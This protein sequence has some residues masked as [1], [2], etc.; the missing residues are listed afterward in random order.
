VSGFSGY[1]GISGFSGYSG[2]SGFSGYS[3]RSGYS[4]I[5]GFSGYSAVSGFS[6]YSGIS[7]FS[8]YSGKSGYSGISGYSGTA[9]NQDVQYASSDG[10][11]TT[12]S[13]TYGS[14]V[15][16]TWTPPVAANYEVHIS[17]EGM[18]DSTITSRTIGIQFLLDA[19]VIN[20]PML[21]TPSAASQYE[22]FTTIYYVA[23]TAA[24]HT[25]DIQFNCSNS[26][27]TAS[28]R[29]ARI[30]VRRQ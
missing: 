28:I 26:L 9:S 7:G 5:S 4:G 3:G 18:I 8:G 20:G 24:S 2:I 19:A 10:V 21:Y 22:S 11:S 16:L 1:S 29:N 6:G 14:K 25:F 27:S 15:T 17:C 12:T 13:A 23:L 30:F